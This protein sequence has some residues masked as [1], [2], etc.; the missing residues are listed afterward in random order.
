MW[1]KNATIL[2]GTEGLYHWYDGWEVNSLCGDHLNFFITRSDNIE[3]HEYCQTCLEQF[4][5]NPEKYTIIK[6]DL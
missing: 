4:Q 2:P 3:E 6:E 1:I 5:E